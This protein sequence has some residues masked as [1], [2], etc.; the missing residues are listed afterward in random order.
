ME[1]SLV[2][3]ALLPVGIFRE[4]I[5]DQLFVLSSPPSAFW[6]SVNDRPDVV[7]DVHFLSAL[8]ME[9]Y[10]T[11]SQRTEDKHD[12]ILGPASNTYAQIWN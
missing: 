8:T 4:A 2:T 3:E 6:I 1:Q 5:N 12:V 7:V 10:G 11:E 9:G